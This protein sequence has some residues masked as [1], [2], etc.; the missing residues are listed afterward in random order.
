MLCFMISSF[1]KLSSTSGYFSLPIDAFN[2]ICRNHRHDI[3]A[4]AKILV[5]NCSRQEKKIL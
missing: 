5:K 2:Q 1:V 3:Q 4:G